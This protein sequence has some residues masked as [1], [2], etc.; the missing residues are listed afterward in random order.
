MGKIDFS[1]ITKD[2]KNKVSEYS[3]E[4]LIGL[5]ITGMLSST[6]LAVKAT[7]KALYLIEEKKKEEDVEELSKIDIVKTCY[8]CY[9][10]SAVSAVVSIG[11][12]IGANS[13]NS[14]RNAILATAYRLSENAFT[15]Y[16]EKVIET[17]GE[18]KEQ[19]VRDKIA[20]EKLEKNPVQS[21]QV[22]ITD[23]GN[24]LCYD[25]ISGRYFRCDID[26][27]RRAEHTL[28][29][30]LMNDMYVSLN[31]FYDLI[32]L[33]YVQIGFDLGWNIDCGDIEIEFSSQLAED[34]SPCLVIDYSVQPKQG[35]QRLM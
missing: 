15:E 24:T 32:G 13:V 1:K 19:E 3:P 7:P 23:K 21:N 22:I 2:V 16:R 5:G 33:P 29:R 12:I 27:I 34:D 8:K 9:I 18:K 11:C 14:R 25:A 26:K 30:K 20:K 4:I 10:P 6:V 28:N 31:E 17:V 35:Y